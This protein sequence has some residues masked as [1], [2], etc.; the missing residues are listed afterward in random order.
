MVALGAS[1]A[2]ALAAGDPAVVL[3][4]GLSSV[5][6][7][8]SSEPSCADKAGETWSAPDGPNA[9]LRAAGRM[10][11]T[12]PA[13]PGGKA[14][15]PCGSKTPPTSMTIDSGGDVDQN[16]K[17]LLQFL[18][19]LKASYGVGE[20]Q[21]VA[22]S[23]GG[24]WSRAAITQASLT[25]APRI[26]SLTTLGT[27][28]TGAWSADMVAST[29][30]LDCKS[31]V[32]ELLRAIAKLT[33]G[34]L[35]QTA[36][37]E[38]T[39]D[40]MESW[41]AQQAIGGCPVTTIAGTYLTLGGLPLPGYYLPTDGLVGEA[42][43]H[44]LSSP[45][46]IGPPIPAPAIPN[47]VNGG[48]FPVVHS[49]ALTFLGT[50]A[51]LLNDPAIA[52]E[53][54]AILKGQSQGLPC[55]TSLQ[56]ARV[57]ASSAAPAATTVELTRPIPLGHGDAIHPKAEDT[58]LHEAGTAITCGRSSISPHG[59]VAPGLRATLPGE[60]GR[61][62]A[63]GPVLVRRSTGGTRVELR[64][65][66]RTLRARDRHADALTI[67]EHRAGAG[68]RRVRLGRDR[69]GH[70]RTPRRRV[71]ELRIEARDGHGNRRQAVAMLE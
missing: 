15:A 33:I 27:P 1:G 6:S 43:A 61:L 14:P 40:Y 7:F 12:A 49:A 5:T 30:G 63:S 64:R 67:E 17:R 26:D 21:L 23:D 31:R 52:N 42:S 69:A 34:D 39:S 60:C 51:T 38:L 16:G 3:V 53:V 35:G 44:A 41:N 9:K 19:F 25:P 47:L 8:T 68:W 57:A 13:G 55:A 37:K 10:V 66:G 11:F 62:R 46:L 65:K 29:A 59:S 54:V 2:P 24:V 48:G 36:V 20:L 56:Q 71:V 50:S 28:H 58:L 4:S 18:N 45:S 22:H 32:C 70:L